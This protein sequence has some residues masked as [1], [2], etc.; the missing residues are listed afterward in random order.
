MTTIRREI[1]RITREGAPPFTCQ[2]TVETVTPVSEGF[3]RVSVRG[4]ELAAYTDVWPADAF[5]ILLPPDGKGTVD[6]PHRGDDGLPF[7]PDGSRRP[8]LRPFTVRYFDRAGLRIDFDV[9]VHAGGLAMRWLR[10]VAA[11]DVI[12]LAGMRHEFHAGA[13]VERHLIV[14][15]A[16]AL[17]AVAAIV[18]ALVPGVPATVYVAVE[19]H[20]DTALLA[21]RPHVTVHWL[22]GPAS[23]GAGSAL[24]TAVRD[25]PR[26]DGRT[27]AW[28]AAE[29]GVVRDLRRF[30]TDDLDVARD[31]LHAAAYWKTGLDSTE[32]DAVAL[33][34]YQ[35]ELASGA[36]VTDPD[37]R[38]KVDLEISAHKSA[39][40]GDQIREGAP[41]GVPGVRVAR[42]RTES[43]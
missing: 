37:L 8:V 4:D 41:H 19:H 7:W 13:G 40:A 20:S 16:S 34:I 30:V 27:Q 39:P 2:V 26:L 25:T 35:R 1:R 28:L 43:R 31:D 18:D 38:E 11:G 22:I 3:V 14:G 29:A 6:F 32:V 9:A 15:D 5:K 24:A 42:G 23:A 12:G 36:D 10:G 17:P 33:G 21:P